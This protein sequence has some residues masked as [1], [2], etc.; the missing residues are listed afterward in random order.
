MKT[1]HIK[2]VLGEMPLANPGDLHKS[3]YTKRMKMEDYYG[4]YVDTGEIMG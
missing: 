2:G 1:V 3:F 4:G